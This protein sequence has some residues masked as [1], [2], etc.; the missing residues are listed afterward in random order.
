MSAGNPTK[1]KTTPIKPETKNKRL[2]KWNAK[3]PMRK[4]QEIETNLKTKILSKELTDCA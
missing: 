3:S 4:K 1:K 2:W